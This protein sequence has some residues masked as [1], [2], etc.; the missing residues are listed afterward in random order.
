MRFIETSLKGAFIIDPEPIEDDRGFFARTFCSRE[1]AE[2]G[3]ETQFVQCSISYNR[4]KGTLRG[5]HYQAPPHEEVKLVRVTFGAIYDVIVDLRVG[6]PTYWRWA[7]VELTAAN[8]RSLYVPMG[9]AH[10]FQTLED[11]TEVVYQISTF[12]A[13]K[14]ARGLRWDAPSLAIRWPEAEH[15]VISTRDQSFPLGPS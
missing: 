2:H 9:L 12:Y 13:P 5:L 3:L 15:R 10:G 6:S 14:A 7:A 8:R 1:F 11:G 4:L